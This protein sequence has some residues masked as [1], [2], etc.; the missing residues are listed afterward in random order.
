MTVAVII[1]LRTA[2]AAAVVVLPCTDREK[3]S[4]WSQD[5]PQEEKKN[6]GV[7]KNNTSGKN[8]TQITT[9]N[10]ARTIYTITNYGTSYTSTREEKVKTILLRRKRKKKGKIIKENGSTK[11]GSRISSFC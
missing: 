2:A 8:N 11:K 1:T 5:R 7:W 3:D 4:A 6:S 10:A 9:Y